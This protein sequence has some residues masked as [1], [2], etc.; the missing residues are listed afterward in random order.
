LERVATARLIEAAATLDPASRA[1]LNMWLHRGLPDA[2]LA[3]MAG[4]ETQAVTARKLDIVEHLSERLGLPPYEI[5]A[6]LGV[7]TPR[8]AAPPR[9]TPAVATPRSTPAVATPRSTPAVAAPRSTAAAP[10]AAEPQVPPPPAVR[11]RRGRR[12]LGHLTGTTRLDWRA[13][14]RTLEFLVPILAVAALLL[15]TLLPQGGGARGRDAPAHAHRPGFPARAGASRNVPV[16][17]RSGAGGPATVVPP[18]P[19]APMPGLR[20][21]ARG[22]VA[23]VS[24]RGRLALRLTVAGLPA[25]ASGHYVVW[26]YTTV[27]DSKQLGRLLEDRQS[28]TLSLPPGAAGYRW[29]DVS[30]QPAGDMVNSGESVLRAANPVRLRSRETRAGA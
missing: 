25:L 4:V 16:R 20:A 17:P 1:L 5:V 13:R 15:V 30:L 9:S 27:I 23:V 6:A 3:Q 11:L 21:E 8:R 22:R 24:W 12:A 26:L 2:A 29:I 10:R 18:V 19:L 14:R 28:V 7:I